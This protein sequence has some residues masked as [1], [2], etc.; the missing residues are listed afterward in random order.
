MAESWFRGSQI[1]A[2]SCQ[3]QGGGN[4]VAHRG[5][6][7]VSTEASK[8]A[9]CF[10]RSL[11]DALHSIRRSIRLGCIVSTNG[12]RTGGRG[13][14][15]RPQRCC[16][17]AAACVCRR[18]RKRACAANARFHRSSTFARRSQRSTGTGSSATRRTSAR[19]PTRCSG[20][21]CSTRC[22]ET[23]EFGRGRAGLT[24]HTKVCRLQRGVDA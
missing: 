18:G 16:A 12:I 9:V 13:T 2:C 8:P 22:I 4:T 21:R 10:V 6:S 20:V 5:G 23:L 19:C 11:F 7:D 3:A 1:E 17:A 14:S 15:P 24:P